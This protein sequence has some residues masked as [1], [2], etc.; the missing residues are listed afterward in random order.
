MPLRP[1]WLA[2]ALTAALAALLAVAV[3]FSPTDF[4]WGPPET[5]KVQCEALDSASLPPLVRD[6][7]ARRYHDRVATAVVREPQNTWSNLAFIFVGLWI[8]ARDR[9][10][11]ARLLSAALI[12]LGLGSG[13]YHA[14]LLPA[15]RNVDVATMAWTSFA[16][17]HFGWL[18]VRGGTTPPPRRTLLIGLLGG[19][20]AIV[21]TT[22]RNHVVIF[23]QKPF[24]T[25]F[26]T[27]FGIGIVC[28]LL[29]RG[30]VVAPRVATAHRQATDR[31]PWLRFAALAA[32]VALAVACQAN[33]RP[34]GCLCRPG[35]PVQGHAGWHVLMAAAI[36]QTYLLFCVAISASQPASAPRRP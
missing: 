21:A 29:I 15:W 25:T 32:T 7:L 8:A 23:G 19:T 5:P 22:L 33:D 12:A 9:R 3:R 31:V 27:A 24:A 13:L 14:S 18:S 36:A 17:C 26:L 11:H 30:L 16:L 10:P 20:V 6:A 4:S 28:V 2:L 35:A 34:G 1:L